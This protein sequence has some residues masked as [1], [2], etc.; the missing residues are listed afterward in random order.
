VIRAVMMDRRVTGCHHLIQ[1]VTGSLNVEFRGNL[2][3]MGKINPAP[4]FCGQ[5]S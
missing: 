1:G 4:S 3:S 5:P 2:Y